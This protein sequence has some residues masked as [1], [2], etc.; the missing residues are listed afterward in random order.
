ME[1]H[2][3]LT[4]L[5]YI[6]VGEQVAF[7]LCLILL[8][9]K[10]LRTHISLWMASNFFSALGIAAS[11]HVLTIKSI[12]D[13]QMWGAFASLAGGICRYFAVSY[14]QRT[15]DH[16]RL[17]DGIMAAAL[18]VTPLVMVS[19]LAQYRLFIVCLIGG[20]ISA[21]CLVAVFRNPLWRTLRGLGHTLFSV[22][23]LLST[24]ALLFRA[25]NSYPF[26]ADQAF[27]GASLMQVLALQTL[28]FISFFLQI[29]FVGMIMA[30]Y[31]RERRFSDRRGVRQSQRSSALAKRKAE[32]ANISQERLDLIQLLTHEVRQP[33]NNAQ[34][35]LQSIYW[36]FVRAAD[37]PLRASHALRR[38]QTSLD[39]ITLALSNV[40][41][42]G[43]LAGQA[44][45]WDTEPQDA[46]AVLEMARLDCSADAQ[47][48]IQIAPFE[49][50][51]YVTATP[52]LLR[53]ALH[54]LLDY[55]A[56]QAAP[57][58]IVTAA[59]HVD[60]IR[61]G[62]CFL[63]TCTPRDRTA[64]NDDLFAKHR[65]DDTSANASKSGLGLFI[66]QQ[67][68]LTHHGS[69]TGEFDPAGNLVFELFIPA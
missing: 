7:G 25:S 1:L 67:V 48:L 40:I 5:V 56:K 57:D 54:N 12:H 37:M 39:E 52:I 65:S 51:L 2:Q 31:D 45:N 50:G 44:Q 69:L 53:V 22:G 18:F 42:A 16:D 28:V 13:M 68:A 32:L 10:G 62:T 19:T 36:N 8:A 26:G 30:R 23:M 29:G 27:V 61:L 20:A 6:Y 41:V 9:Q 66:A 21:A 46:A 15:F 35:S 47:D 3:Y 17:A 14:R 34:A 63:V 55:A 58:T 33:I 59:V 24:F 4:S 60:D 64:Y 43:T 11:P 49:P 38:A